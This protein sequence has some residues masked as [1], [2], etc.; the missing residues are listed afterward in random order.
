MEGWGG[1]EGGTSLLCLCMKK[2]Q[3][4]TQETNKRGSVLLMGSW[5]VEDYAGKRSASRVLYG[6][7]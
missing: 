6:C 1:R 4:A 7:G 5:A 3:S 2:F